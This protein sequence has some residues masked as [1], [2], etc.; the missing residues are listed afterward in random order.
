MSVFILC[1]QCAQKLKLPDGTVL[2]KKVVCPSCHE[3]FVSQEASTAELL[4]ATERKRVESQLPAAA[5]EADSARSHAKKGP[6]PSAEPKRAA[7][8]ATKKPVEKKPPEEKRTTR[9]SAKETQK[10]KAK[11]AVEEEVFEVEVVED[12]EWADLAPAP[13]KS[14]KSKLPAAP[15]VLGK[16]KKDRPE[17]G[18][19]REGGEMSLSQHRLLMVGTGLI[20]AVVAT[21]LWA[22]VIHWRGLGSG[23]LA[24]L[25]GLCVGVGV[26]AGASKHDFGWA[27][28]LTASGLTF[29]A[30]IGGKFI[31]SQILMSRMAGEIRERQAMYVTLLE[32]DNYQI[33]QVADELIAEKRKTDPMFESYPD[34]EDEDEEYDPKRDLQPERLPKHYKAALWKEAAEKWQEMPDDE[35]AKRKQ[36]AEAKIAA[37]KQG[38]IDDPRHDLGIYRPA[39]IDILDIIWLLVSVT[40]AFRLAT[41]QVD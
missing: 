7:V 24:M 23:W 16:K 20:G 41:G 11:P 4:A 38:K 5:A 32:H 25:V 3:A 1:P 34:E 35:K 14:R 19:E 30:I 31:A 29:V 37:A 6:S 18:S 28:A 21:G 33:E 15:A 36:A 22:A 2:G 17:R 12:D 10:L 39:V 27:P 9:L 13:L 26:R 8:P 40:A